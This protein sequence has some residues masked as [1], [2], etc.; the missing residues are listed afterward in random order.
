MSKRV[1]KLVLVCALIAVFAAGALAAQDYLLI[2]AED[3][4]YRESYIKEHGEEIYARHREIDDALF[5]KYAGELAAKGIT[6]IYT[7][8]QKGYVEIGIN[9]YTE[10]NAEFLYSLLGRDLLKVVAS[11]PVQLLPAGTAETADVAA[12]Q[13]QIAKLEE[14]LAAR[15]AQ[16]A[17]KTWAEGVKTRNGALQYAMLTPGLKAKM[18]EE[19]SVGGTW[20]TGTSSPWVETYEIITKKVTAQKLEYTVVFTYTD[21]TNSKLKVTDTV[22][23]KKEGD[24]WFISGINDIKDDL[25]ELNFTKGFYR[26]D[27]ETLP[28]EIKNWVEAS[29]QSA[30]IQDKFYGGQRFVLVT[31]GEKPSGGYA[32]EIVEAAAKSGKLQV[33]AK[34]TAP[35]KDDFVTTALTYPFD[36][37]IVAEKDLPLHLVEVK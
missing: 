17:V 2:R 10:E 4:F 35:G 26:P 14:A 16:A 18:Y 34:M 22:T 28:Q 23:V 29:R 27:Y 24:Y 7:G 3:D 36:L 6:V 19:L 21:S 37:V 33:K 30:G 5:G 12:L 8:P 20:T 32:V 13:Q 1:F 15:D 31:A 9:P 25:S 11:E